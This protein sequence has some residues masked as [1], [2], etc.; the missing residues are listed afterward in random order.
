MASNAP[1]QLVPAPD[2]PTYYP[3][4][5]S[6]HPPLP[7]HSHADNS[8]KCP[9]AATHEFCPPQEGDVRSPCPALN[10]MANHGY[11]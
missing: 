4:L 5:P 2:F 1:Q 11:M 7:P 3:P 8:K 10:T 9:F 6:D